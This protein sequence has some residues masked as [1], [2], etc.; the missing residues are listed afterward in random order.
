MIRRNAEI[1]VRKLAE[2]YPVVIITGPRQSGKTTLALSAFPEKEYVSL[3]NLDIRADATED[4]RLFL[5]RYPGGAILDEV[6]H[7]PNLLS[8]MQERVDLSNTPGLFI[9]TGS[10]RFGILSGIT[11]SLAGRAAHVELLPFSISEVYGAHP[12]CSL[13]HILLKGLY[14]P[15]HDRNLDPHIWAGNYIRSYV[16]RDVRQMIKIG[17]LSMFQRFVGLCAARIGQLVSF[18]GLAADAGITHNTAKAWISLLEASYIVFLLRPHHRNFRKRIIKSPKLYFYDTGLASWFLSIEREREMNL[19]SMRGPFF[20]NLII[21]E[22]LKNRYNAGRKNNLYF[23]RDRS[24]HEVDIVIEK[25][26]RLIPVE[27]KSGKTVNRDFFKALD[28][29]RRITSSDNSC[30]VYGG[31]SSYRIEGTSVISWRNCSELESIVNT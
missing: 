24:G 2:G 3:E 16:E 12:S 27:M 29:W 23:W 15:V 17:D 14:P 26:D 18:S 13:D 22:M 5:D 21:S 31:D 7:C 30:L 20:E 28:W 19:S 10:Q 25:A 4:P 8:Y 6:Q 9:L 1:T 11:Q